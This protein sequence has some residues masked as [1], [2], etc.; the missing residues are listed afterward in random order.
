[1]PA[2]PIGMVD[3][4]PLGTRATTL[5]SKSKPAGQLTPSAV[6]LGNGVLR[7]PSLLTAMRVPDREMKRL[8]IARPA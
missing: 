6:Q 1:M 4:L 7:K 5:I 3:Q 2:F 8:G